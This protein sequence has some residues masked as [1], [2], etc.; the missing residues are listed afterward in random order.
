MIVSCGRDDLI[1]A[2]QH[3]LPH[4]L[5][6]DVRI[7]RLG[8]VA[9]GGASNEAALA[10]WVKPACRF[11]VRYYWSEW[12][13]LSLLAARTA[14]LLLLLSATTAALSAAS[15]LI[16][17]AT[18][19]VSVIAI[20]VAAASLFALLLSLPASIAPSPVPPISLSAATLKGARL[21]IVL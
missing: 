4:Y 19:V 16:A 12:R 3:V 11:A 18:T 2:S 13:A 10:L 14:L 17:S 5:G 20:A 7:A 1:A 15:T 21:R 9:V 8:E 6:W